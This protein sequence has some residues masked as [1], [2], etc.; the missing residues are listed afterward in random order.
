MN[1]RKHVAG[2]ALFSAIVGCA[3]FI[4]ALL[5]A[6]VARIPPVLITA[7]P[8]SPPTRLRQPVNYK[9]RLV[10]LD[11]INRES[12]TVLKL[13]HETGQPVPEKLWVTTVFSPDSPSGK[14]FVITTKILNPFEN[15][16]D[17]EYTAASSCAGCDYSNAPRVGYFARVYVSTDEANLYPG[18]FD[19]DLTTA[20]PVVVQ[21]E[22]K[23]VF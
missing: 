12:Y 11:F 4:N 8:M 2:F 10:S 20:I 14:S 7:P 1:L 23:P 6:P 15:E 16:D 19:S 17:L 21:A 13:K 3:I 22:R 9:V 5:T 18:D